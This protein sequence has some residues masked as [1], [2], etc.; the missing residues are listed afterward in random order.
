MDAHHIKLFVTG[1]ARSGVT[2]FISTLTSTELY[3][4]KTQTGETTLIVDV[5]RLTIAENLV[6]WIFSMVRQGRFDAQ[7]NSVCTNAH[8]D[9]IVLIVDSRDPEGF[10]E[11]QTILKRLRELHASKAIPTVLV[12][13]KQDPLNAY[14]LEDMDVIFEKDAHTVPDM[15]CDRVQIG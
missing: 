10:R 8:V 4:D 6:V 1:P 11:A 5:G 2:T 12:F 9:G 13:N 15:C 7:W 14:S 3:I